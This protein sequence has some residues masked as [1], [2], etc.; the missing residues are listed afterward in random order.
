MILCEMDSFPDFPDSDECLKY[1]V[2]DKTPVF[3]NCEE[4]QG[5]QCIIGK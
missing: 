5:V 4:K 1:H 3:E 2:I